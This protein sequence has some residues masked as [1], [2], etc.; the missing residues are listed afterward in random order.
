MNTKPRHYETK[1]AAIYTRVSTDKQTIANQV[2][3]L[4]EIAERR[5]WTI[6]E[7]YHD[8]GI[9]LVARKCICLIN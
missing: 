4:R 7:E 2:Q 6:V 9:G 1:R 5:G 3:A 8:A